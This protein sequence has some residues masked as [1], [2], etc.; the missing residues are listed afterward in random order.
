MTRE[1]PATTTAPAPPTM[2]L[3]APYTECTANDCVAHGGSST[4]LTVTL[5]PAPDRLISGYEYRF[6]G[7]SGYTRTPD[8]TM[9]WTPPASGTYTFEVR[10]VDY[11]GGRTGPAATIRFKVG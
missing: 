4:P 3:S 11:Y 8:A 7:D 9:T 2:T 5:T 1:T 6:T 10:A